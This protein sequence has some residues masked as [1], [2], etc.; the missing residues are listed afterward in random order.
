MV[1]VGRYNTLRVVKHVDFGVYLDGGDTEILLPKRY[2]PADLDDGD[3]IEVFIYHDSESRL[4]ATTEHPLGIVGDI[5]ILE[6]VS[7]TEQGAFLRWGIMKDLFVPLSQQISRMV[8]GGSY[9]VYIYIDEQ[10]GRVA[11]TEKTW[12]YIDN[13]N[14]DLG[15]LKERDIVDLLIYRR[16]DL[17]YEVIINNKN[18]GLLHYNEVFRELELGERLKGFIKKIRTDNKIDVVLGQPGY[19]KVAPEE[20][21]ILQMLKESN[22][23]LP[24]H[25]KSDPEEIYTAFGMSKKTFK[26]AVGALY[27]QHKIALTKTGIKLEE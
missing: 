15:E 18:I 9:T 2:V 13:E 1:Q 24:Y 23:Y 26:M 20:E 14:A 25:D 5:V 6:C 3:E 7:V 27:K 4:V 22:G 8:V 10:T 11:A 16:T 21:K 19:Q 12:P 17:G